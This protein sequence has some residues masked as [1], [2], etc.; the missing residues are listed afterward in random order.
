MFYDTDYFC[1][2]VKIIIRAKKCCELVEKINNN[3]KVSLIVTGNNSNYNMWGF[4]CN[5]NKGITSVVATGRAEIV[6]DEVDCC[7]PGDSCYVNIEIEVCDIKGR[8]NIVCM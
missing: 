8:R 4:N 5:N 2:C 1:G 7:N 3:N 6:E